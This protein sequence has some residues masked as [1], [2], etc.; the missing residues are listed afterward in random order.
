VG[1]WTSYFHSLFSGVGKHQYQGGDV[2]GH[3]RAHSHFFGEAAPAAVEA[4]MSLNRD[5]SDAEVVRAL[6]QL[7]SHKAP[8]PDSV[9]AE[10]FKYAY[11]VSEEDGTRDYAMLPYL[12]TLF[13]M[14][15]RGAYPD[16]W[17]TAALVPVPKPKGDASTFDGYRGIAVGPTISKIYSMLLLNRLDGWAEKNNL[18]ANGQAGFRQGRGTTDNVFVL[19]HILD[20]HKWQKRAVHAAFI[21]FRKAYDCVDRELL[22]RCLEGLGLHGDML[23]TLRNM[24]SHTCLQV[25]LHGCLGEPFPSDMGVRQ[26]DPLSPLLFGLFIDRFEAFLNERMAEVGGVAVGAVRVKVLLY[27]DDIVLLAESAADLQHMLDE[28]HDFC[29]ATCMSV[30]VG[31]SEVVVF[32]TPA[33]ARRHSYLYNG[34]PLAVKDSFVYLGVNL[35]SEP[36]GHVL[37]TRLSKAR[38]VLYAMRQRCHELH[39]DNV[40]ARCR[41]FDALVLPVLN[42]GCEVWAPEHLCKQKSAVNMSGVADTLH[43]DFMRHA[44]GVRKSTPVAAMLEELGGRQPIACAWL[45]QCLG[46]Y[47]R[48]M[49]RKDD[50]VV[51]SAMVE[52][53]QLAASGASLTWAHQVQQ[54]LRMAGVHDQ[55]DVLGSGQVVATQAAV[56]ALA[57]TI[58]EKA[59]QGV[60]DDDAAN[61]SVVR[62]ADDK[63][64][65]FKLLT[66]RAWFSRN[67]IYAGRS[68]MFYVD[69]REQVVALAR[70]RLGSHHLN[71]ETGR[72]SRRKR[73][74]R[75]PC[76]CCATSGQAERDDELHLLLCPA[77]EKL[78]HKFD[79]VFGGP[80]YQALV[81]S[82]A[83]G[84]DVDMHMNSFINAHC[85][86]GNDGNELFLFWSSL[87]NYLI[88]VDKHRAGI[89]SANQW[90]GGVG[91]RESAEVTPGSTAGR[92]EGSASGSGDLP[93]IHLNRT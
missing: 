45:K 87:S 31:K 51:R 29:E 22:W 73:S 43:N 32:H 47:N 83:C 33:G 78:R 46:F 17:G 24:Y 10:F 49:L 41:L 85:L 58:Q 11:Y 15:L 84:T 92:G 77:Y 48:I 21:D 68:F 2:D 20:K 62:T 79:A 16:K 40:H 63:R 37:T 59:W 88:H 52:N 53:V 8:G 13:N 26:G 66:Y 5:F 38:A 89:V 57:D 70:F 34:L 3:C 54:C 27:A 60:H 4:A 19:R 93:H 35:S 80:A 67:G 61:G 81:H 9:P 56:N 82:V 55:A 76:P 72:W 25:R 42:Y 91:T 30:N 39:L 36:S 86:T 1:Q 28:L 23:S 74:E 6:K 44:L 75:D 50:D 7:A 71:I 90:P 18:R 64:P 12:T 65:C 14:V 69:R